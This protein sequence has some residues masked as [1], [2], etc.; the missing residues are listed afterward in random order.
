MAIELGKKSKI[1]VAIPKLGLCTDNGA[2]VAAAGA[3]LLPSSVPE[4]EK[5]AGNADAALKLGSEKDVGVICK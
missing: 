1:R 4:S 2:M 3:L 5:W